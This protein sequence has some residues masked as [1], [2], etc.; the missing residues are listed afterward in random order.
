MRLEERIKKLETRNSSIDWSKVKVYDWTNTPEELEE[1]ERQEAAGEI[2][3]IRLHWPIG[4]KSEDS[5][6]PAPGV[7][8]KDIKPGQ[9]VV[10]LIW[11]DKG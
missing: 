4:P 10:I 6:K 2:V 8:W 5:E 11:S 3:V 7:H 1:L 9:K